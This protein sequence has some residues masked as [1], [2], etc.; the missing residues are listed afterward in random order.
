MVSTHLEVKND[1]RKAENLKSEL[2]RSTYESYEYHSLQI[3]SYFKVT[4][5]KL[6]DVTA[7]MVDKFICYLLKSGKTDKKT[8]QKGPLAVRTVRS[9]KSVLLSMYNQAAILAWPFRYQHN[10][11]YLQS[12]Q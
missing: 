10:L 12:F 2:E 3:R 5:P 8:H 1:K 7:G 6:K 4:N 11:K 9:I